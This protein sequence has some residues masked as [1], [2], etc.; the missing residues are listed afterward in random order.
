MILELIIYFLITL[1]FLISS[2]NFYISSA[3][4]K[5]IIDTPIQNRSMHVDPIYTSCGAL[6]SVISLFNTY[7]YLFFFH[8]IR[9]SSSF[10]IIIFIL[11]LTSIID[12]L[13]SVNILKRI[14]IYSFSMVFTIISIFE[15]QYLSQNII[16]SIILIISAVW[17]LNLY[18]FMDN[19]DLNISINF[20]F[21]SLSIF[22]FH[23]L[24]IYTFDLQSLLFIG[25]FLSGVIVFSFYN[26]P[27]AKI[28]MGDS[29]SITLG[30]I[31][32]WFSLIVIS[33]GNYY[34]LIIFSPY[35]LDA[36]FT[37][38]KRLFLRKNILIAH[39]EHINQLFI[40]NNDILSYLK[41]NLL[42][43]FSL[44][45]L[46]TTLAYNEISVIYSFVS[47]GALNIIYFYSIINTKS[48]LY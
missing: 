45:I 17:F 40:I 38:L 42:I 46:M 32:I 12:D 11:L 37:L 47:V 23:Y 25:T 1:V 13:I 7:M 2:I 4:K 34:I 18:N 20:V 26:F 22:I 19:C 43:H 29:G 9:I 44:I 5:K 3:N 24:N 33:D 41:K 48:K 30:F 35:I 27:P 8:E 6:F 16:S 15:I 39:K 36:T 10:L 14:F 28:F 21:F 31:C